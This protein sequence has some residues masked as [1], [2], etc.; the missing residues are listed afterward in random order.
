M[1]TKT[2]RKPAAKTT[3]TKTVDDYVAAAPKERHLALT[4]LRK[5]IKAAAPKATSKPLAGARFVAEIDRSLWLSAFFANEGHR[6]NLNPL[7][8]R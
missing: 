4:K 2:T 8:C 7:F 3:R 1:A 5:T 6:C